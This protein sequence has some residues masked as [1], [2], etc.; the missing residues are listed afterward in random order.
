MNSK[1]AK[2]IKK[3]VYG[4]ADTHG[5]ATYAIKKRGQGMY[6]DPQ[7]GA[8]RFYD[9]AQVILTPGSLRKKY[10]DEKAAYKAFVR[11]GRKAA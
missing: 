8:W 11:N 7:T 4:D 10:K 2:K 1:T 5:T 3:A 9:K 6:R